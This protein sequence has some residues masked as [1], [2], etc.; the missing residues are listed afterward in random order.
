MHRSGVLMIVD[1]EKDILT[2]INLVLKKEGYTV[3]SFGSGQEAIE[4]LLSCSDCC[5]LISDIRMPGMN[6]F[7]LAKK[8]KT[9]RPEMRIILASA[10]LVDESELKNLLLSTKVNAVLEK[11]FHF[12]KLF[13]TID[14]VIEEK[15]Q[16]QNS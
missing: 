7:E 8:I 10:Y 16:I 6:G 5:T 3:H 4:H 14:R 2:V 13:E 1:D 11:P 12:S 15:K 9:I